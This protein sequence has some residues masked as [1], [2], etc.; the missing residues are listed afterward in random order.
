M[1]LILALVAALL[2]ADSQVDNYVGQGFQSVCEQ[3]DGT[4]GK[5]KDGN[6]ECVKSFDDSDAE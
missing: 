5:D 6:A 3:I 1:S 4:W 2:V